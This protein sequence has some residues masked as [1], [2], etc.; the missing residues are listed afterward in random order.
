MKSIRSTM[1]SVVFHS[2]HLSI[3]S[4]HVLLDRRKM[5]RADLSGMSQFISIKFKNLQEV[6]IRFQDEVLA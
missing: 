4:T 6:L 2:N 1:A 3:L 5:C